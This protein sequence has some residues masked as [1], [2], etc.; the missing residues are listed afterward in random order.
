MLPANAK[1]LPLPPVDPGVAEVYSASSR[2]G[3]LRSP[4]PYRDQT[5]PRLWCPACSLQLARASPQRTPSERATPIP[6]FMKPVSAFKSRSG[7]KSKSGRSRVQRAYMFPD[8]VSVVLFVSADSLGVVGSQPFK[9]RGT[10]LAPKGT[11]RWW[12]VF[13]YGLNSP[14]KCNLPWLCRLLS[15]YI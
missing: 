3:A 10:R 11:Y 9:S 6:P 4:L 15:I 12:A 13:V 5:R 2:G 8:S 14:L 1:L 7:C